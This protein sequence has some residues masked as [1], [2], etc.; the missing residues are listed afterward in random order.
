MTL[1]DFIREAKADRRG[2]RNLFEQSGDYLTAVEWAKFGRTLESIRPKEKGGRQ[3]EPNFELA[4]KDRRAIAIALLDE[5]VDEKKIPSLV[6][7]S[8]STWWRIRAG[9]T[10]KTPPADPMNKRRDVSNRRTPVGRPTPAYLDATSGGNLEAE[11]EF[12]RL[13]GLPDPD[14]AQAR[15]KKAKLAKHVAENIDRTTAD[16]SRI[17]HREIPTGIPFSDWIVDELGLDVF[18][19]ELIAAGWSHGWIREAIFIASEGSWCPSVELLEAH[20][21]RHL[22]GQKRAGRTPETGVT[23][24]MNKR[25]NVSK[26]PTPVGG[27]I[28][29]DVSLLPEP[30]LVR[31]EA[32]VGASATEESGSATSTGEWTAIEGVSA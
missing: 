1:A 30:I 2:L 6:S 31:L 27:P 9:H 29:G 22:E 4:P 18:C 7:L 25:S 11:R 28:H 21:E 16:L 20:V 24:R 3:V 19:S 26:R 23:D 5:G 12:Y 13:L 14:D 8:R 15:R 10:P 32:L 17:F